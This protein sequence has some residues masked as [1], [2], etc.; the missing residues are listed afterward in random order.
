LLIRQRRDWVR[1]A[2]M[3][4]GPIREYLHSADLGYAARFAKPWQPITL[5][6]ARSWA[7]LTT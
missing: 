5:G 3:L 7:S 6:G 1:K 2:S 4:C